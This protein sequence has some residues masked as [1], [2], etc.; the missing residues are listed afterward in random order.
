MPRTARASWPMGRVKTLA[1]TK[2]HPTI[3]SNVT[4]SLTL[5]TNDAL[6]QI[7]IAAQNIGAPSYSLPPLTL[8]V[9]PFN[10]DAE[11]ATLK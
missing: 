9:R 6:A 3:A 7:T 4:A 2:M 1:A 11:L 8:E 5:T 10:G